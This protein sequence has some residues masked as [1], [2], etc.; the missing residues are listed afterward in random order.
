MTRKKKRRKGR[1]TPLRV[2]RRKANRYCQQ[3]GFG[4]CRQAISVFVQQLMT[5]HD[6]ETA[7][8]ASHVFSALS[9]LIER[10]GN[11]PAPEWV[12]RDV[13]SCRACVQGI[14]DQARQVQLGRKHLSN[15]I[16]RAHRLLSQSQGALQS[17][18]RQHG[19]L[20]RRLKAS[21]RGGTDRPTFVIVIVQLTSDATSDGHGDR[22]ATH[23]REQ[24][25]TGHRRHRNFPQ[26]FGANGDGKK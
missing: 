24:S 14:T 15:R 20:G 8:R 5:S 22:R 18:L 23:H 9:R 19:R 2:T 4:R 26:R 11:V 13:E 17:F 7:L 6:I 1:G 12:V 21:A 3:L 16:K 25:T 10:L